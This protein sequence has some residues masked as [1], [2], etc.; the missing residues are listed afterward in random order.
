MHV[1]DRKK[2]NFHFLNSLFSGIADKQNTPESFGTWRNTKILLF[3]WF[4]F[5]GMERFIDKK[6]SQMQCFQNLW[7]PLQQ[8]SNAKE[9]PFFQSHKLNI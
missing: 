3:A 6:P 7:Q 8:K 4:H 2:L 1:F 9:I 5:P